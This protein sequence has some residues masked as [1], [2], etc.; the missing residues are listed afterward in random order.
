MEPVARTPWPASGGQETMG[1]FL[2]QRVAVQKMTQIDVV[3]SRSS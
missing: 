2:I 3:I 1:R